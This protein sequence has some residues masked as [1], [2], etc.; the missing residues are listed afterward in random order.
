MLSR[1]VIT[2][3]QIPI[4]GKLIETKSILEVTRSL[5]RRENWEVLL[6]GYSVSVWESFKRVLEIVV[7][8]AQCCGLIN[9]T[10]F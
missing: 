1:L 3:L 4:I 7:M 10:E 9:T 2:F 6:S 5:G 8:V